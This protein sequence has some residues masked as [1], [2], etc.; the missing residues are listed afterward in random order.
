[1]AQADLGHF[2]QLRSGENATDRVVGIAQD[3]NLGLGG[4]GLFKSFE[5]HFI[6]ASLFHQRRINEGSPVVDRVFHKVMINRGLDQDPLSGTGKGLN[7]KV[8]PRNQSGQV[9][10]LFVLDL[11]SIQ[12][13]QPIL[14]RLA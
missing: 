5:I 14:D 6:G 4:D 9:M 11:P 3:E 13:F 1:V 12:S 7:G 8:E 2:F 10:N